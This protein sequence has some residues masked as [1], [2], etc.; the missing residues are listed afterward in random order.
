MTNREKTINRKKAEMDYDINTKEDF[1]NLF[2][3]V[4]QND[5]MIFGKKY[6]NLNRDE[7]DAAI[8]ESYISIDRMNFQ[9]YIIN[10]GTSAYVALTYIYT[11]ISN[12]IKNGR[13]KENVENIEDIDT[14]YTKLYDREIIKFDLQ[15]DI[16]IVENKKNFNLL[17]THIIRPET[18]DLLSKLR[19]ILTEDELK[20][21]V[22]YVTRDK[23]EKYHQNINKFGLTMMTRKVKVFLKHY[24]SINKLEI[25]DQVLEKLMNIYKKDKI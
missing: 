8:S 21:Y 25:R 16:D 18:E 22:T 15:P 10:R 6:K 7:F 1:I 12:K 11:I 17:D 4:S 20:E 24:D 14:Q 5:K 13:K 23:K 2:I 3:N 19:E 9:N